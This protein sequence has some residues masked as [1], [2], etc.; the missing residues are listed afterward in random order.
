MKRA[1][2][3]LF[4]A[5]VLGYPSFS[6]AQYTDT[7]KQNPKEY[8]DEDSQPLSIASYALY[9]IGF[10]AEWLVARPLHY[11][12]ADT[13]IEPVFRPADGES[14]LPAPRLP[15]IPDNSLASAP[16]EQE[17]PQEIVITPGGKATTPEGVPVKNPYT[18]SAEPAA[19]A[20]QPHGAAPPQSSGQPA[21]H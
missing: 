7:D 18:Q 3:F 4:A 13:P 14:G 9:P 15:I 6:H 8:N 2:I 21:L 5:L 16:E 17:I 12:T 11:V 20:E 19:P 1:A 10:M